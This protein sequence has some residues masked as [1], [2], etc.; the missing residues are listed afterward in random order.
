MPLQRPHS[1]QPVLLLL[2]ALPLAGCE[3]EDRIGLVGISA[4]VRVDLDAPEELAQVEAEIHVY[5]R[6]L[7]TFDIDRTYMDILREN[8][9]DGTYDFGAAYAS[10]DA[11]F[12][13]YLDFAGERITLRNVSVTNGELEPLCGNETLLYVVY[14]SEDED[15]DEIPIASPIPVTVDCE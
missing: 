15:E 2:L 14:G 13:H 8:P 11:A 4:T 10:E 1:L 9:E 6:R 12:N 5:G 7:T 3:D